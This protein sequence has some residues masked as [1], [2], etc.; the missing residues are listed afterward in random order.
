MPNKNLLQVI[1]KK[2]PNIL[3]EKLLIFLLKLTGLGGGFSGSYTFL[4]YIIPE[5]G[6]IR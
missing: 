2:N 1:S 5:T 6:S 3:K 4:V